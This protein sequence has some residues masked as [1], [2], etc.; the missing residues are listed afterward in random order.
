MEHNV[1][2]HTSFFADALYPTLKAL[3]VGYQA[4]CTRH[5]GA[6]VG[7]QL[8]D[9]SVENSPRIRV[10]AVNQEVKTQTVQYRTHDKD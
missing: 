1:H 6:K 7:P 10:A 4:V 3:I 8:T 9:S 5:C 2:T